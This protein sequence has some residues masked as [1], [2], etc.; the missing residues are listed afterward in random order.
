MSPSLATESEGGFVLVSGNPNDAA[1]KPA[2][3]FAWTSGFDA[4][5]SI[6]C[7]TD[8]IGTAGSHSSTWDSTTPLGESPG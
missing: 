5:G 1:S 3:A 4:V 8:V 7:T 6:R 2:A